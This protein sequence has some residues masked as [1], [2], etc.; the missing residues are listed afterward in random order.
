MPSSPRPFPRSG[1]EYNFLSRIYHQ[2]VGFLAGWVSA[3]VGFA[4]PVAAAAMA[5]GQYL[6]GVA[7]G[8]PQF[9]MALALVWLAT[10]VQLRGIQHA[11]IFQNLTDL[12]E[13][14]ADPAVHRRRL[15][16]RRAPA[17][18]VCAIGSRLR[19]R[20]ERAVLHQPVFRHV[21]LRRLE[22]RHLHRRRDPRPAPRP[23]AVDADRRGDRDACSTSPSMPCSS[24]PR[25]SPSWRASSTSGLSPASRSS[26]MPAGASSAR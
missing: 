3:T 11:S 13:G 15:G 19:L 10:L 25:R 4:A 8:I 2:A 9:L 18:L 6:T 5:F 7:P 21:L 24:T 1:G 20:H 14:G 26:A 16:A 22:R 23:A 12:A 17:H